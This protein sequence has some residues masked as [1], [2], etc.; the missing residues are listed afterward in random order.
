MPAIDGFR[1]GSSIVVSQ[2][3][4]TEGDVDPEGGRVD[5]PHGEVHVDLRREEGREGGREGGVVSGGDGWGKVWGSREIW[6]S[7]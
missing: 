5:V 6:V 1:L 3:V 2:A 7:E 4:D